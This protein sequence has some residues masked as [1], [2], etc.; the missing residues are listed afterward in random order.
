[1]KKQIMRFTWWLLALG[2]LALASAA[3]DTAPTAEE[4]VLRLGS[5]DFKERERAEALL[6]AM[7]E[8]AGEALRKNVGSDNP[9]IAARVRQLLAGKSYYQILDWCVTGKKLEGFADEEAAKWPCVVQVKEFDRATGKIKG[10][11]EWKTLGSLVAIEGTLSNKQLVF[12]EKAFIRHGNSILNC[13]YTFDLRPDPE[14]AAGKATGKIQGTW[15]NPDD[16][17]GGHVE[18]APIKEPA[19]P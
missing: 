11:I 1:M 5:E 19:D 10:T 14:Q 17:R 18:L 6:G 4:L 2:G 15:K 12:T 16:N 8:K 3:E 13:V 9:E 7:G